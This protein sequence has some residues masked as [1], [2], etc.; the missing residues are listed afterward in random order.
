[1]TTG[2]Y[3]CDNP[4]ERSAGITAAAAA[5][6]R[7]E[8]VVLPTDTVYGVGA[9]AFSPAAV[10]ALLAAKGRGRDMPAPVLVASTTMLSGVVD[11]VDDRALA[12]AERFWP[13]A[14]SLVLRHPAHLAWDLG[15]T[16]GTVMVRQPDNAVA[17]D[18]IARTGP[19]ATSSA[20]RSG[21][22]PATT[23]LDARLQLG[24]AVAVYLDGGPCAGSVPS[25]IVDLTSEQPRVLRLGSLQLDELREALPDLVA[26]EPDE[27]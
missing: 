3:D 1:M 19:L 14:L 13:G 23:M 16:R 27:G 7:G 9:D 21:H 10:G 4:E 11:D 24:A 12:L 20:N 8:L 17:L 2:V 25:T 5:V 22:P 6:R 26:P 18:L 15:E